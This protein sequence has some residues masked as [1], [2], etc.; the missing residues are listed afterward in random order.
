M[1][2]SLSAPHLFLLSPA[3]SLSF[4]T[5]PYASIFI[6]ALFSLYGSFSCFFFVNHTPTYARAHTNARTHTHAHIHT[7]TT[8]T[9]TCKCIYQTHNSKLIMIIIFELSKS[10]NKFFTG[11]FLDF[12][13]E[14]F[15]LKTT[16]TCSHLSYTQI[17][18]IDIVFI[19][20]YLLLI[21]SLQFV[22]FE[23]SYTDIIYCKTRWKINCKI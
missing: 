6:I 17:I 12:V 10:L 16:N 8:L 11:K 21:N 4:F 22:N 7:H 18:Y 15:D 3:F 13:E 1:F 5:S 14:F 20:M 23:N 2:S 9:H 19:T